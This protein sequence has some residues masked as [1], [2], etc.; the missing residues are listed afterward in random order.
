MIAE[1]QDRGTKYQIINHKLFREKGCLF[2]SR[3]TGNE[4]FIK[5][6]LPELD[7]MELIINC[8]DYPQISSFY[9]P[10]GPVLSFSKTKEYLDIM[11]PVWS[12]Y[13]GGKYTTKMKIFKL[14]ILQKSF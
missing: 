4:H 10:Q 5:P 7:N 12:F 3:C 9:G 2:P 6:L 11:Y 13:E 8:R 14:D 1:V